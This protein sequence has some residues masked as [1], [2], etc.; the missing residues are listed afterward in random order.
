MLQ[1]QTQ[2]A[3]FWRDQFEISAND[4]D[5]LYDLL[6]E[7]QQPMTVDAFAQLLIREYQRR[8][9]V[10]IE[11]ELA[12]GEIYLPKAEHRVGQ[13]LVFPMLDFAVGEVVQ[14]RAGHNP[15]HGE[16]NVITVQ[17]AGSGE[18]REFAS[19]LDTPHRLNQSDGVALV[20]KN[21]LLSESEI[22][23]LYSAEIDE[24]LLFA[25]EES[26]RSSQFVNVEGAWMFGRHA[27]RGPRLAI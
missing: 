18:T 2:T 8:E 7:A 20:D 13:K 17:F 10:K 25:L 26:E 1:R 22:Y 24:S 12:K 23:S 5:F 9:N 16:L 11:Q 3:A 6:L 15:E 19:D 21:A 27:G 14:M 4:L